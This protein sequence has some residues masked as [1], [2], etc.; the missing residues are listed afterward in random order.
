MKKISK[1]IFGQYLLKRWYGS[2]NN[3]EAV[4]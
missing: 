3:S 2:L 4:F 1:V